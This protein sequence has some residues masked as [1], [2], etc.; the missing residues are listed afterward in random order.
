MAVVWGEC[1]AI[2]LIAS[3]GNDSDWSAA[4]VGVLVIGAGL[5]CAVKSHALVS[6]ERAMWRRPSEEGWSPVWRACEWFVRL[7]GGV[8]IMAGVS[9]VIASV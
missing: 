6:S 8:L 5:T 2:T 9:L 7:G 4:V 1:V 3:V